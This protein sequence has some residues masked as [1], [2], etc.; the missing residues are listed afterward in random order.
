VVSCNKEKNNFV[1]RS[2]HGTTT[3][4]NGYFNAR[5]G[6]KESI[7]SFEEGRTEDWEKPLPLIIFPN[8]QEAPGLFPA[9]DKGIEKCSRVIN[10]HSMLI[11]K[12]EYNQWIDD[13]Y[14]LVGIANFYKRNFLEAEETFKYVTKQYK[15][16][17]IRHEAELWL[18]RVAIEQKKYTRATSILEKLDEV[19][20][21]WPKGMGQTY[22][23]V[24]T[25]LYMSQGDYKNAIDKLK[26]AQEV[27]KKKEREARQ[28]FL[29]AQ[30]YALTGESQKAV[31]RYADVVKMNPD[32]DMKFYAQINQALAFDSR[33]D[34]EAIRSQLNKM[35]RD[36]KYAEFRDQIYYALAEVEFAEHHVDEGIDMLHKSA[37]SSV[38][39]PKQ[40]GKSFLR[41]AEIYFEERQYTVASSYY[42][43]T[44]TYLPAEYPNYEVIKATKESLGELVFHL[45]IVYHEDSVQ[46]IAMLDEHDMDKKIYS[47]IKQLRDE[48][49]DKK[50]QEQEVLLSEFEAKQNLNQIQADNRSGRGNNSGKW[51]FYN[52]ASKSIGFAEF[53]A[54]YG[55]RSRKD[56]WRR[57]DKTQ[58]MDLSDNSSET[59][60][61]PKE[62]APGEES[63]IATYEEL[64]AGLPLTEEAMKS[65]NDTIANS[66]FEIGKIYKDNLGDTDNAIETFE[67]M[68]VRLPGSKFEQRAYY[69]LYRL[70]LKKEEKGNYFPSDSR[71]TSAYYK[72]LITE[73]FPE[74]EF[75]KLIND[76]EYTANHEKKRLEEMEAYEGIFRLYRQRDY[77]EVL[78]ACLDVMNNQPMNRY[79]AKY[80]L[81]RAMAIAGK[82]DRPNF[83][84][85][86][87]EIVRKHPGTE[88]EIEAKRLLGIL[89]SGSIAEAVSDSTGI[90]EKEEIEVKEDKPKGDYVAKDDMDHY[91]AMLI[92]NKG[93][94]MSEYK[95]K[96]A[97]FNS[98][99]FRSEPLKVTN[100]FIDADSQILLVRTFA[101]KEKGMSYLNA[102]ISEKNILSEINESG[103]ETFIITS[104]NFATLFKSK[105][106][107]GYLEFFETNYLK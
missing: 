60:E 76:P 52:E 81:L 41:L 90:D 3:H 63:K 94:T 98:E 13:S 105:D 49:A 71:S 35:L 100:S 68:T 50:R 47:I 62:G 69:Q 45:D 79:I 88:E 7:L 70:Y 77:T 2:Y 78:V 57:K 5:E 12:K 67:E 66:M 1:S 42:D 31:R 34:S 48:E 75:A 43:S 58:I 80:H 6:M 39:N 102:F 38:N 93:S 44:I 95:V 37:K 87:Q 72:A 54:K 30:L 104:K 15:T 21:D 46:T 73:D 59:G 14:L 103:F 16:E 19:K 4:F 51:Y 89:Q 97:D 23:E 64:K 8:E 91:F 82:K 85:A 29:L 56:N 22:Y 101:S 28:M 40:K 18:A 83:I 36:E 107:E 61:E 11:K 84:S 53:K 33:S 86:L 17:Q 106:I 92:P 96:V 65:S 26:S 25:N 27:T 10:R 9:M 24:Y 74:S 20:S 55:Q 32:Y 99:F